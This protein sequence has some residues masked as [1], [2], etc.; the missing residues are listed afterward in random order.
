MLPGR[1]LRA[2]Q[3]LKSGIDKFGWRIRGSKSIA[4]STDR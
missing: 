1:K 2:S 3:I 4:G